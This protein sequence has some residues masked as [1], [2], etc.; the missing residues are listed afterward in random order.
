VELNV[1]KGRYVCQDQKT[2][3]WTKKLS[4]WSRTYFCVLLLVDLWNEMKSKEYN[5]GEAVPKSNIKVVV[6]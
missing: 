3:K 4:H 1:T 2:H 6:P 5:I